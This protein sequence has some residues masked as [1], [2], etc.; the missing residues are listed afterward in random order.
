MVLEWPH[1]VCF[2]KD[3]M[4]RVIE[5]RD[6]FTHVTSFYI[7]IKDLD[8]LIRSWFALQRKDHPHH[9]QYYLNVNTQIQSNTFLPSW[10]ILSYIHQLC[11]HNQY[12]ALSILY[13][14]L[15][16]LQLKLRHQLTSTSQPPSWSTPGQTRGNGFICLNYLIVKIFLLSLIFIIFHILNVRQQY[17]AC[18][19]HYPC[20]LLIVSLI[21][22]IIKERM[23]QK[24]GW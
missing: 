18:S 8:G 2:P 14:L 23:K 12:S 22:S 6:T 9:R 19:N 13:Y 11:C 4:F 15:L 16:V 10:V 24:Y 20:L 7:C 3:M 21:S 5:T 17:L 1:P